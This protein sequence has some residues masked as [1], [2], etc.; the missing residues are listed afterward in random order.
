M[1]PTSSNYMNVGAHK[2]LLHLSIVP[3]NVTCTHTCVK[4]NNTLTLEEEYTHHCNI[5][6]L[7]GYLINHIWHNI[8]PTACFFYLK[9]TLLTIENIISK[10][11]FK[12]ILHPIYSCPSLHTFFD[13]SLLIY[14]VFLISLMHSFNS[15]SDFWFCAGNL[16]G[17][18]PSPRVWLN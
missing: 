10:K 8:N 16:S 7:S 17:T 9:A 18:R 2:F 1:T 11:N 15:R 13:L 6:D 5:L 12:L 4:N 3:F 14:T